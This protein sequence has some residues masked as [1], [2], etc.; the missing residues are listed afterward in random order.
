MHILF[1]PSFYP[2]KSSPFNGSFF[3]SQAKM[4]SSRIEKIGVVYTE[5]KSLKKFF[6]DPKQSLYQ[7]VVENDYGVL[8][9]RCKGINLL[10]QFALGAKI[11][12]WVTKHL[13]DIY[14]KENGKPDIIH[15]HN[16]FH[17]GRVAQ[18][19]AEEYKIPYL[20][21]EHASG[22]LLA[23]YTP[24]QIQIAKNVYKEASTI[25]AVSLE[26]TKKI[27]E[28]CETDLP[29]VLPNVV[30]MRIF[31]LKIDL[32]K[33]APFTFISVG[34]LLQNKGHHI[35]IEAF[36]AFKNRTNYSAQLLIYG[37][38]PAQEDLLKMISKLRLDL[39]VFL[40]GTLKSKELAKAYQHS[41]CLVLPS[42]KETFGVVLIEAM[43]CGLPV[44]ATKSGGPE[45]LVHQNNGLLVESGNID[46]MS[47]ALEEMFL[48]YRTYHP[49]TISNEVKNK[50]SEKV[51]SDKLI[52]IYN[53]IL[54]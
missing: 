6:F 1:I 24:R 10:N 40:K 3:K 36:A 20:I 48:K 37:K 39:N 17:A 9:Y 51:I 27:V 47:I 30:D 38:G 25:L 46:Q 11:W 33:L 49:V 2:E 16:V 13:V 41:H 12:I 29:I 5:Q 44:I 50:Y 14:I 7:Y 54:K 19:C 32:E 35:L 18:K 22:F 34:N 31:E 26:L 43:A 15:A 21:T 28:L 45:D 8:T 23:E 42:F 4:L 53:K 52:S